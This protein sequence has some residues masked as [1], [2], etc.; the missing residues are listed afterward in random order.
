MNMTNIM[1]GEAESPMK[2]HTWGLN[3]IPKRN[4]V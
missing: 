3:T 2:I 4:D 1:T